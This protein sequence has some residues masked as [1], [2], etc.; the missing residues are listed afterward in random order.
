MF[1]LEKQKKDQ[2]S[3]ELLFEIEKD[4]ADPMRLRALKQKI[5]LRVQKVKEILRGGENK[6]EFDQY[7]ALLHGYTSMLKVISRYKAKK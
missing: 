7:G 1:G 6:E 2:K 3:E 5:E 4:L